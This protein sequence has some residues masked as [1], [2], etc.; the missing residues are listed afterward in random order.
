MLP[1]KRAWGRGLRSVE[2]EYK[3]IK[4]KS[5]FKLDQNTDPTMN[6]IRRFEERSGAL[7]HNSLIKEATHFSSSLGLELNLNYPT[8]SCCTEEGEVVEYSKIKQKLRSAQQEKLKEQVAGQNWQGELIVS[9]WEDTEQGNGCFGWLRKWKTCRTFVAA[10]VYDLYEQL[11]PTRVYYS[12]K[13]R[14]GPEIEIMCR[15][16]GKAAESVGHI[17][18]GCSALAQSKY[19]QRQ[20]AVLKILF[21]EMLCSLDLI[22]SVPPWY[23]PPEPK[24]VYENDRAQAFWNVPVYADHVEVRANRI[25]ARIVDNSAK[26]VILL[27]MSCPWPDNRTSKSYEKTKKYAPLRVELKKQFQAFKVKQFNIIIDV[28]GGYSKDLE[29]TIRTLKGSR[30]KQVLLKTQKAALSSSLNIAR[31]FKVMT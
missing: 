9:R 11:L 14:T 31:H 20:N 15:L 25:D 2:E 8:L 22:H 29:S 16:C 5:A 30:S 13:T 28:L 4:I 1:S 17:L 26:T 23:S 27:E 12:K 19:L 6:F 24:S 3:A 21:F 7:G 10:G 18:A